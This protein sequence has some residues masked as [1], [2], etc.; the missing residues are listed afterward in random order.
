[1][2]ILLT[3]LFASGLL[4]A[5]A[6]DIK[7]FRGAQ[8]V[9]GATG[10]TGAQGITGPTGATGAGTT[11]AT[12]PTGATGSNGA[13]GATGTGA[14]GA[15]GPTGATGSFSGGT[16]TDT[17]RFTRNT[18][19]DSLTIT[20]TAIP[21]DKLQT[22]GRD[23]LNGLVGTGCPSDCY[24]L[25]IGN[26]GTNPATNLIG[27]RDAQLFRMQSGFGNDSLPDRT[28]DLKLQAS[29]SG[30]QGFFA[31]E[32]IDEIRN[33]RT[34]IAYDTSTGAL[35]VIHG[36]MNSDTAM[37][38]NVY[39]NI[40]GIGTVTG[41]PAMV[42]L[43]NG[44]VGIGT[45][46]PTYRLHQIG[47]FISTSTG[48]LS[49]NFI[50]QDDGVVILQASGTQDFKTASLS[51]DTTGLFSVSCDT[52]NI[53]T[54]QLKLLINAT[55]GAGKVLTSDADGNATWQANKPTSADSATIYALSPDEF[56]LYSCTDCTGNGITGRIVAYI[57]AAWRRLTFE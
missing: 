29:T 13:T 3:I 1:M 34:S 2:R 42:V 43:D 44:N 49:D 51:L 24:W 41:D 19:I 48:S 45:T 7:I 16:Y 47:S 56:T 57:G 11:G 30:I 54:T 33:A 37:A 14:T 23:T 26:S 52:G 6:Q 27:T 53:S 28:A 32:S 35:S 8:G 31:L 4:L 40:I 18:K 36:D 17:I 46:A 9:T 5:S 55:Q 50:R 22:I 15:T 20:N 10:P 39:A 12:G 21:P 38:V 25:K